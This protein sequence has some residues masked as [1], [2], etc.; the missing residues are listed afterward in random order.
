MKKKKLYFWTSL[1]LWILS[2]WIIFFNQSVETL[3]KFGINFNKSQVTLFAIIV[4]LIS[5]SYIIWRFVD[6]RRFPPY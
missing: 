5:N 2:S 6:K 1:V 3:N 4:L